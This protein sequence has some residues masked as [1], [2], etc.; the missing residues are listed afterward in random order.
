VKEI[1]TNVAEEVEAAFESA[2]N[3]PL[4]SPS[5]LGEPLREAQ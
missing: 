5:Q 4:A 2:L 3:A 1:E